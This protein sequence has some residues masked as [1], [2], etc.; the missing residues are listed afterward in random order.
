M[1]RQ[2][3]GQYGRYIPDILTIAD[4]VLLNMLFILAYWLSPDM[5]TTPNVRQV[6][7][8]VNVAYL[9]VVFWQHSNYHNNRAIVMDLTLMHSFRAVGVHALFFAALMEFV[10][11]G[12]SLRS[13]ACFYSLMIVLLPLLWTVDRRVIKIMRSRGKNFSRVVIVGTNENAVRLYDELQSDAGFGYRV[14]GFFDKFKRPGF[15]LKYLGSVDTLEDF[16]KTHAIDEVFF[17]LSGE[18]EMLRQV[19]KI[20]DDNVMAFYYVPQLSKY[21]NRNFAITSI[22]AM[23]VLSLMHNPLKNPLNS[24]IKRAFDIV[25]SAVFLIFSPL[26]FIPVAIGIKLSSPGPIFFKQERTGYLGRSFYCYKF[27]TMR[28]NATADSAQAT[29][30]DP[31]K[32]KFGDFLRRTSIDELPQFFNVLRGDMSVV[33]PRPHMLKHTELYSSIISSY[34]V[35]HFVRPGITGWAQVNG[36]RG[37]TDE[38]WKMEKRVEHDVWYIEH[39]NFFLDLKIIVRTVLNAIGGEKN[40]F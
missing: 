35:R 36:Y 27:R 38:L 40:A 15:E 29:K 3:R 21:V 7:L 39:W 32:T 18:D 24:A 9:P 8:L 22:G 20:T 16:I 13:Y 11:G 12:L 17:A 14:F 26:I 19:V 4:Y 1:I 25:F 2:R 30:D 37:I 33:G 5:A 10:G 23:P 28:V 31:R 34:M 6:W